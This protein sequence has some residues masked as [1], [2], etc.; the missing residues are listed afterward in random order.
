MLAAVL[1]L[2]VVSV[3]TFAIFFLVPRLAGATADDMASRYAGKT[4]NAAQLSKSNVRYCSST[5][6][7]IPWYRSANAR[8]TTVMWIGR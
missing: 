7:A 6:R 8:R 1:M 5:A 2:F 3:V 4:A